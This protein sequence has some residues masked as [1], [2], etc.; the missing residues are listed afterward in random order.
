MGYRTFVPWLSS[1][2]TAFA[3]FLLQPIVSSSAQPMKA[4]TMIL[5]ICNRFATTT[6]SEASRTLTKSAY[7]VKEMVQVCSANRSSFEPYVLPNVVQVPCDTRNAYP[8]CNVFDWAN[9]ADNYASQMMR[10]DLNKYNTRMYILPPES[11]CGFGGLGTIGPCGKEC[12]VWINGKIANEVS[13]YFHELGHNLG[14]NHASHLGDQYGDFTDTM[15]YCCNIR[16]LSAPNTF[17]LKWSTPLF[18]HDIPFTRPK[19]YTL[20]PNKY[21]ILPDRVRQEYTF[22]QLRVPKYLKYDVHITLAVYIYT[23]PFASYSQSN[24]VAV[25]SQKGDGWYSAASSYSIRLSSISNKKATIVMSPTNLLL[26]L[27]D[28]VRIPV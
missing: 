1:F 28:R 11:G 26:D 10:I 19:T 15:G 27:F 5:S 23:M 20:T 12:R 6:P 18:T 7:N 16:C 17:R 4:L 25:L 2:R 14:L 22:V 3:T 21:L 24:Y 13:V 8:I 9:Y